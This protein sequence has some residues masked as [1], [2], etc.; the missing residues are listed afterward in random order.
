MKRKNYKKGLVIKLTQLVRIHCCNAYPIPK[1]AIIVLFDP[2][3]LSHA[4]VG[5]YFD[6]EAPLDGPNPAIHHTAWPIGEM[7]IKKSP[8]GGF[9]ATTGKA[10]DIFPNGGFC[11]HTVKISDIQGRILGEINSEIFKKTDG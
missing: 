5:L 7:P 6:P 8:P 2:I 1:Y 4:N 3:S 10:K 9:T 11:L